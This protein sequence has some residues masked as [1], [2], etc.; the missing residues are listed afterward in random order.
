MLL[1][2]GTKSCEQE[3]GE[4]GVVYDHASPEGASGLTQ[5]CALPFVRDPEVAKSARFP[6]GTYLPSPMDTAAEV[7]GEATSQD[8]TLGFTAARDGET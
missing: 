1:A 6:E 5:G 4:E 3:A 8:F 7:P 2:S